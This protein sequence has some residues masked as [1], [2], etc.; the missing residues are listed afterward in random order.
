MNKNSK[1]FK[2]TLEGKATSYLDIPFAL[3]SYGHDPDEKDGYI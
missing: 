2:K 1:A 3:V